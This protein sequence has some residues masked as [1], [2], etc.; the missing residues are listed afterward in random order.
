[1]EQCRA[2]RQVRREVLGGHD[3]RSMAPKVSPDRGARSQHPHGTCGLGHQVD[4]NAGA[5][6]VVAERPVTEG[7]HPGPPATR[8]QVLR[9]QDDVPFGSTELESGQDEQSSARGHLGHRASPSALGGVTT[10]SSRQ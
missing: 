2:H 1:L 5:P 9:Q 8:V 10:Q 3:G 7:D 6:Q 4:G